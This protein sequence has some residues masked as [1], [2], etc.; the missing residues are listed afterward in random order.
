MAHSLLILID[1]KEKRLQ[2]KV[3]DGLKD[4]FSFTGNTV[5]FYQFMSRTENI[6]TFNLQQDAVQ[7]L[8]LSL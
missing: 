2:P 1:E 7:A 6:M 8:Y 5:S 4:G 3:T